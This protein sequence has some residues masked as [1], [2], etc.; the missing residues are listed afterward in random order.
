[1]EGRGRLDDST[2]WSYF[3]YASGEDR[4]VAGEANPPAVKPE[5]RKDRVAL[6]SNWDSLM[7]Y[8]QEKLLSV[9]AV[10]SV[11]QTDTGRQGEQPKVRELNHVKELG[12]IAP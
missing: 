8:R 5:S 2:S 12:K 3:E 6:R 10:A 1:M 11:P 9:E 4:R 7:P